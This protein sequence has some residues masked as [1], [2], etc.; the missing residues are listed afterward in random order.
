MTCSS[1]FI[2]VMPPVMV[3]AHLLSEVP[4]KFP[5]KF[6]VAFRIRISGFGHLELGFFAK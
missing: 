5:S 1:T 3:N 6:K 2:A 4:S